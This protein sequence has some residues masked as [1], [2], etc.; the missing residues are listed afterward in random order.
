MEGAI[1]STL[2]TSIKRF[3]KRPGSLA[4]GCRTEGRRIFIYL[5]IYL[6]TFISHRAGITRPQTLPKAAAVLPPRK[7]VRLHNWRIKII[8]K[9]WT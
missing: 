2:S 1:Y 7:G 8:K 9:Q 6:F 3:A 4:M 5:F